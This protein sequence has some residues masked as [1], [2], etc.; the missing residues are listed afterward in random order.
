[1]GTDPSGKLWLPAGGSAPSP[2]FLPMLFRS[3]TAL[4][5]CAAAPLRPCDAQASPS[6]P[7][8][9][10]E[11]RIGIRSAVL[12]ED[13]EIW[14]HLPPNPNGGERF[15]VIY[16]LD[17]H[18]LFPITSGE[19]DF[20]VMMQVPPKVV[21]VGITSRSSQARGRDFTPVLDSTR[22]DNFPTAGQADRFL[23]F[24]ETEVFPVI[25]ERYPVTRYRTIVGHSL[26][27][28]FV[29]HALATKPEL[30]ERYVAISPTIPW[31][32]EVV[33][34]S[35]RTKLPALGDRGLYVSVGNEARGYQEGIDHLETLLRRSAP[36]SL[37][38]KVERYPHYDH[39]Q[40]VPPSVHAGITFL[41]DNG[42]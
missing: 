11:E 4:L 15:D 1:M 33:L 37:R 29:L 28:L 7:I 35:L 42:R 25:E 2:T 10:R 34:A 21:V 5:L 39:T 19:T 24:L 14:I 40:V 31:G 38:W 3:V 41:F 8:P 26:A 22:L 20:R 18:A 17:G 30:F 6:T 13:R 23:R 36:R 9:S 16:V 27:G 12:G 32:R